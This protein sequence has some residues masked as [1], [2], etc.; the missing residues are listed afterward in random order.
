MGGGTQKGITDEIEGISH[1]F[2][3]IGYRESAAKRIKIL[4]DSI[5]LVYVKL[6]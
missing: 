3:V 4:D 5:R 2:L 6:I 1:E